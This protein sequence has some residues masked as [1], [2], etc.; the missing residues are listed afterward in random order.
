LGHGRVLVRLAELF[1]FVLAIDGTDPGL[2]HAIIG[3]TRLSGL[4]CGGFRRA[5]GATCPHPAPRE[6]NGGRWVGHR[7]VGLRETCWH[8]LA[9]GSTIPHGFQINVH[10]FDCFGFVT[11]LSHVYAKYAS[12]GTYSVNLVCD[13]C[14]V[15]VSSVPNAAPSRANLTGSPKIVRFV[16]WGN[17]PGS[18]HYHRITAVD[19]HPHRTRAQQ[20]GARAR[21]RWHLSRQQYA[22][23]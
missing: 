19:R 8:I 15:F 13:H 12:C 20:S 18:T 3:K 6:G 10:I 9:I 2:A 11:K 21:N 17:R 22:S 5:G 7:T 4:D 14:T 1:A 16:D 23:G